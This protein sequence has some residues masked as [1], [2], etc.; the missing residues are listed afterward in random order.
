MLAGFAKQAKSAKQSRNFDVGGW[1][2]IIRDLQV[3]DTKFPSNVQGRGAQVQ[4]ICY[5]YSV[6]VEL[7]CLVAKAKRE[8][9]KGILEN[10]LKSLKALFLIGEVEIN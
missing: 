5:L 1:N 7:T 6:L 3:S 10:A 9:F 2:S 8:R 4:C